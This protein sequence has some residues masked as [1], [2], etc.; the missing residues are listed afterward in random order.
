LDFRFTEFYEVSMYRRFI[1]SGASLGY[2][3]PIW[4]LKT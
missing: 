2:P 1:G 4:T 3:V